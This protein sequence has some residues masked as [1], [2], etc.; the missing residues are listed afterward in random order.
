M[1]VKKYKFAFAP[2]ELLTNPTIS[3]FSKGLYSFLQVFNEEGDMDFAALCKVYN[4]DKRSFDNALDELIRHGYV[5]I[6]S[7]FGVLTYVLNGI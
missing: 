6:E 7:D 1:V 5:S 2:Y 4:I 3:L